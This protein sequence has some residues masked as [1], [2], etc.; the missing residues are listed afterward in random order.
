M[1]VVIGTM[2][3][4]S[5]YKYRIVQMEND[6]YVVQKQFFNPKTFDTDYKEFARVSSLNKAKEIYDKEIKNRNI[7]IV[8]LKEKTKINTIKSVIQ[9]EE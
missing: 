6:D 9:E 5:K 2:I 3:M 4:I 7:S 1:I 8:V